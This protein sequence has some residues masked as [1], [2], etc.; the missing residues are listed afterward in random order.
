MENHHLDNDISG[1]EPSGHNDLEE[2]FSDEVS[3]FLFDNNTNGFKHFFGL[4]F[5]SFHDGSGHRDNG[6]HD[7]LT[8]TS[9]KGFTSAG[10]IFI[11]FP[12]FVTSVEVIVSPEFFHH[13]VLFDLK[14]NGVNLSESG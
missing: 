8:E 6:G 7:E 9:D 4:F 1:I 2:M 14:F 13:F 3:F 12:F 11:F 10:L 5:V